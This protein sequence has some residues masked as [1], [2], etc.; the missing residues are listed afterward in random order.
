MPSPKYILGGVPSPK[1]HLG[2]AERADARPWLCAY[3]RGG[4]CLAPC[5]KHL[6]GVSA[7]A[8]PKYLLRMTQSEPPLV[9]VL[10]Q[11]LS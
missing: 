5:L 3:L 4:V 11:V 1:Y 6:L 7:T 9:A 8:C 10:F 2:V